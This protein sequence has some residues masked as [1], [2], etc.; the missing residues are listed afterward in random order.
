[1]RTYEIN[2]KARL[3]IYD[4]DIETIMEMAG[5]GISYWCDEAVIEENCYKVHCNNNDKWYKLSH[6]DIVKGVQMAIENGN[7]EYDILY[8]LSDRCLL[9]T[10]AVDI[11]V[12]DIIIQYACFGE[13]I[14]G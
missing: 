7:V 14:Y 8:V 9:E 3:E 13:I 6:L 11:T 1:M 10:G 4:E 12:A 5:Y 2:V